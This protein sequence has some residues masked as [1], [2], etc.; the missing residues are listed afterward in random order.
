MSIQARIESVEAELAQLKV[1]LQTA[2]GEREIAIRNQIA[3][4]DTRLNGYLDD[5]RRENAPS[6]NFSTPFH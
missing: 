5:L 6:G 2:T 1:D 4:L 3:A